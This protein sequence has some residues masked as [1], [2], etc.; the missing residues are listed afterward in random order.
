MRKKAVNIGKHLLELLFS[1]GVFLINY[2]QFTQKSAAPSG[3]VFCI[4]IYFCTLSQCSIMMPF[5]KR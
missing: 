1:M 3:G 4:S 5:S 2:F